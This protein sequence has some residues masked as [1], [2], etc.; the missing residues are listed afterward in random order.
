MESVLLKTKDEGPKRLLFHRHAK[1][2]KTLF[3]ARCEVK[4]VASSQEGIFFDELIV[5]IRIKEKA[6]P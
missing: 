4:N 6:Q 2:F 1:N 5:D 3:P